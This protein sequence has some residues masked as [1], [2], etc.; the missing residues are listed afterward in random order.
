MIARLLPFRLS[1]LLLALLGLTA[2]PACNDAASRKVDPLSSAG[3]PA[4]TSG[5]T[6]PLHGPSPNE[7]PHPAPSAADT[8]T[9]PS[10]PSGPQAP[11]GPASA[12]TFIDAGPPLSGF[13]EG[14]AARDAVFALKSQSPTPLRILKIMIKREAL[15][16]DALDSS[17]PDTL[18]HYEYRAG[19]L[20]PTSSEPIAQHKGRHEREHQLFPVE[21]LKLEATPSLVT[22]AIEASKDR[23][24]VVTHMVLERALPPATE[25]RWR[26]FV[27]GPL[28]RG[29]VDA[30]PE[31]HIRDVRVR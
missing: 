16:L 20:R 11:A 23:E 12:D 4:G 10:D 30:S 5:S 1:P 22:R 13:F 21:S 28:T 18:V 25:L 3:T 19:Q 6:P 8:T 15:L 29:W 26:L 17:S 14:T 31:G 24:A 7:P 27:R 9:L 2:A